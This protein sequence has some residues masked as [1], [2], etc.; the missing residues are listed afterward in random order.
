MSLLEPSAEPPFLSRFFVAIGAVVL[1]VVTFVGTVA[2]AIA[3]RWRGIL[4]THIFFL[5]VWLAVQVFLFARNTYG[6]LRES[7]PTWASLTDGVSSSTSP[8]TPSTSSSTPSS[9]SIPS[10]LPPANPPVVA[11]SETTI[12]WRDRSLDSTECFAPTK[13]YRK[14]PHRVRT[15]FPPP[16]HRYY[17]CGDDL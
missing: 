13:H 3:T 15:F 17:R 11:K 16:C 1:A 5:T 2:R 14:A 8:S 12:C 10:K 4:L 6:Y 9:S 7:V